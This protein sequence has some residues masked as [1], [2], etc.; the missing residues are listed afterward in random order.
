MK[1]ILFGSTTADVIAK[2]AIPVIAVPESYTFSPV[3]KMLHASDLKQLKSEL[4]LALPLAKLF[5]ASLEVAHFTDTTIE[6]SKLIGNAQKEIARRAYK[7]LKFYLEAVTFGQTI[8]QD[9]KKLMKRHQ[10]DMLIMFRH[11]H[12]WLGRL[13]FNSRTENL[14]YE[15]K[16]PLLAFNMAS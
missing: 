16:V 11:Q 4:N 2:S 15:T 5:N 1:K 9:I 12:N 6:D 7:K 10:P 3:K 14:V 8:S 13:F